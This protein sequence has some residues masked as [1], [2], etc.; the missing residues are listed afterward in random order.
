MQKTLLIICT[1]LCSAGLMAQDNDQSIKVPGRNSFYAE[2]GG[3]G[4]LFSANY[5]GRFNKSH[6]GLG[7][8]VGVG[9]V[10]TWQEEFDQNGNWNSN[11]QVS[12]VTFPAQLNYIFGKNNSP[13]TFEVGAGVTVLGRKLNVLDFDMDDK[14]SVFGTFSFMYR[15]QPIDGGFTWRIGFTPLVANGFIQPFAAVGVGYNF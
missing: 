12:V 6:L 13:H 5:D 9:F 7:G 10:T 11:D 15:R 1:L 4:I 2:L 14:A 3:P 8:R